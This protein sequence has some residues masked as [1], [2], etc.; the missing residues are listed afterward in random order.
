MLQAQR[1]LF[2]ILTAIIGISTGCHHS[3]RAKPLPLTSQPASPRS[4]SPVK[5]ANLSSQL[6]QRSGQAVVGQAMPFFSGWTVSASAGRA[7]SLRK[8]LKSNKTRYVL[9]ICASWCKP[10]MRGL[11]RLSESKKLFSTHKT[12]LIILVAD[13]SEHGRE[14]FSKFKFD[15]AHVVVDEFQNF[16][17]KLAP[18]R[19]KKTGR[20]SLSLPRTI[21]FNQ[22]GVIEK[23]IGREADDYISQIFSK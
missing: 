21:I 1:S 3:A 20:D 5:D 2:V 7:Y 10:C 12:E 8:A 9:T 15:W 16:A 23:I 6:L 18:E 22:S 13:S 19:G 17:L 4:Q 14:I 11:Q